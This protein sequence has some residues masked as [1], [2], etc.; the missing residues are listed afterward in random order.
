[1][2]IMRPRVL[3]GGSLLACA[4][5]TLCLSSEISAQAATLPTVSIAV[6]HTSATVGGHLESGGV[7]VV[8][9]DTGVKEGAVLLFQLKPGVTVAEAE[10]FSRSKKAAHDPNNSVVLGSIVFDLEVSPGQHSEAQTELKPGQY[11]VL[12][13]EGEGEAQLRSSFTVTESK[14]PVALPAPQA[15][16]RAI[17][18]GFR[19]PATL[20]DGELVG[21]ENEGFLVHMNVAAPVRNMK[22]AKKLI[23]DL[24]S[25]HEKGAQ[26]L[27][28]GPPVTFAG[29]VSHGAYQQETITAKPG[30]YVEVCF[31]Q[32][33]DGRDHALLGMERIIRITK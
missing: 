28:A 16:V 15:K 1:M 8:T 14:S 7:N 11:V 25:G 26:K 33:Q 4:L 2:S 22:N 6:T 27:V 9:S 12:V 10:A 24:R 18:F 5:A 30:I 23:R 20:H 21:F 31:M 29:P 3:L 17:D 13:S 19:G 32:T